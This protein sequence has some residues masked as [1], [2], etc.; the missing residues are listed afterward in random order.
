MLKKFLSLWKVY[1]YRFTPW[2]VLNFDQHAVSL[3]DQHQ[4]NRLEIQDENL[5]TA[6]KMLFSEFRAPEY[7]W[8]F[9]ESPKRRQEFQLCN[10]T[11]KN[12]LHGQWGFEL[13]LKPSGIP[14]AGTGVFV[15]K[16]CIQKGQVVALYPGTVY[17]SHQPIL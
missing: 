7:A 4:S 10:E 8:M 12:I 6:L 3:T 13:S 15:Q 11:N 5:L 2:Q 14:G 16:G 1:R 9:R 17:L